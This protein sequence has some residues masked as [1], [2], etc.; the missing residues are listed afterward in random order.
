M[1]TTTVE[2]QRGAGRFATLLRWSPSTMRAKI[3]LFLLLCLLDQNNHSQHLKLAERFTR[4]RVL[5]EGGQREKGAYFHGELLQG[6]LCSNTDLKRHTDSFWRWKA[7][8][9]PCL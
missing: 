5:P 6:L 9:M 8:S 2:R 3:G 1:S 7:T 4:K